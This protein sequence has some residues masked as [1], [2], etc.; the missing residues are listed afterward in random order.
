MND[1]SEKIM[2]IKI[3]I[4]SILS[5]T[6]GKATLAQ[7]CDY[8][9]SGKVVK[10]LEKTKNTKKYTS[11][12]RYDMMMDALD[13]DEDCLPCLQY[14]GNASFKRAKRKGS[15]FAPAI[16][17]YEKLIELC[18]EYHSDPYYALGAMCYATQEYDK[19]KMYFDK[20]IHFPADDPSKFKK[21]YDRKYDEVKAALPHIDFW[22]D[23]Y[24]TDID[25]KPE[26]VLGVSSDG[27]DYLPTISADGEIMFYTRKVKKKSLGDAVAHDVEL[28]CWSH[29]QDINE[30]FDHGEALPKPFNVGSS[31]GGATISVDNKEMYIA[32]KNPVPNNKDNIDIYKTTYDYVY[33]EKLGK[34]V[35]KWSELKLL[36]P[37]I[38]TESGWESQPSLSGD[39][40]M[41]FF[42]AVN[43]TTIPDSQG[44]P[45][46]DILVSYRQ[47]DGSWGPAR[48][49]S[50]NINTKG[51]EKAPFMHSDSHT[52][53]FSSDGHFGRGKMDIF[54]SKLQEDGSWSKPKNIGHP[55]NTA[56]DEVGLIVS[57]DGE[58]AY[59]FS[60]KEKGSKGY[61]VFS[62]TMPQKH[63][64]E[65][66]MV[67]KG[68]LK[69]E[70]DHAVKD[71]TIELTYAE[72][73]ESQKIKVNDDDG[74]YAA[75]VN[76]E[77]N[78]NVV[79]T[80]KK[81][82]IAFNSRV[83]ARKDESIAAAKQAQEEEKTNNKENKTEE[84]LATNTEKPH[85]VAT[86]N[87][88][89]G[90]KVAGITNDIKKSPSVIKLAIF[91]EKIKPNKPFV[92]NDIYYKTNSS[93]I[94]DESKLILEQF[95]KYLQD[96]PSMKIEIR[97]HTDNVGSD[98]D[99]LAL[100]MDR[101][102]EVKG[103][104][105]KQGVDGKRITAKGFG[106]TK[107]IATNDN[108]DGRSKNRRT[109]FVVK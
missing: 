72:S 30:T 6:L 87:K 52:L 80:V 50:S 96:N 78:E 31:Y 60:R 54:Y 99:N 16:N 81:E 95:A 14:L 74:K 93:E 75:I 45:S 2:K 64:P 97:G 107:P 22:Q 61:D 70:N 8:E 20:F 48:S 57:A 24:D 104:L 105:E 47:E 68:E 91:T 10:L 84:T 63:R 15:S 92:I 108:E 42:A 43:A 98:Q 36:G 88:V 67:L 109:E 53:Y 9:P 101:S 102:F 90:R 85:H 4:L 13:V 3:L 86:P 26:R 69:D 55:I 1:N 29:R 77:K 38:N 32:A 83:I 12:Q 56:D 35:Y 7:D 19:A 73:K 40:Q 41:L 17:Y 18:P 27:D 5:L 44:N 71:A 100:S 37:N 28:F 11:D 51:Q 49:V 103:F 106:E 62:F 34:K 89:D 33:D 66:V 23:F 94:D 46:H 76:I 39:G 65:K 79:L 21:N 82:G 59:F 25:I 58:K